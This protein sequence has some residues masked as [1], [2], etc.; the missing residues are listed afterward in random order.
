MST[1]KT[2]GKKPSPIQIGGF[3]ILIGGVAAMFYINRPPEWSIHMNRAEGASSKED[4]VTMESEIDQVLKASESGELPPDGPA[5]LLANIFPMQDMEEITVYPY[6]LQSLARNYGYKS[7]GNPVQV[8]KLYRTALADARKRYGENS[9]QVATTF[10]PPLIDLLEASGRSDEAKQLQEQRTSGLKELAVKEPSYA[11]EVERDKQE[12]FEKEGKIEEAEALI[13]KRTND[14]EK[15]EDL[16]DAAFEKMAKFND[17]SIAKK[18]PMTISNFA[19]DLEVLADFY[20]KHKM[21]DKQAAVLQRLQDIQLRVHFIKESIENTWGDLAHCYDK[22]G[23]Y[24]E[25]AEAA[26]K[27]L[28]LS[29]R[30]GKTDD[31]LRR[32]RD[33][34]LEKAKTQAKS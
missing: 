27:Q 17:D 10:L 24:K 3:A 22:Q 12:Q 1:D 33:G 8:E 29:E 21:Y 15:R 19:R 32:R 30:D 31:F 14:A 20:G 16:S 28:E 6:V 26:T 4:W 7:G 34:Y 2:P 13:V 25:A 11:V 9:R 18:G 5:P 23:K